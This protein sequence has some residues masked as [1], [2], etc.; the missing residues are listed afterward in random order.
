MEEKL[1][2]QADYKSY[3]APIVE[4]LSSPYLEVKDLKKAGN[5]IKIEAR[6]ASAFIKA[7]VGHIT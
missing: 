3:R 4:I 2:G 5:I 6:D 7:L 1:P